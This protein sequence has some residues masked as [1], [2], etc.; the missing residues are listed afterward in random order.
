MSELELEGTVDS[1]TNGVF[2]IIV[3][4]RENVTGRFVAGCKVAP[5]EKGVQIRVRGKWM[6]KTGQ[7][8]ASEPKPPGLGLHSLT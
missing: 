4:G 5:L 2:T 7:P 1:F 3:A 6:A 8:T